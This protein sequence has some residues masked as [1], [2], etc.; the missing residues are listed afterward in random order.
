MVLADILVIFCG[1]TS[2]ARPGVTETTGSNYKEGISLHLGGFSPNACYCLQI[3]TSRKST[4]RS[5]NEKQYFLLLVRF[6]FTN[7]PIGITNYSTL[8]VHVFSNNREQSWGC[9]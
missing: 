1:S 6:Y 7:S 8:L 3:D 4:L 5:R 9:N 2:T